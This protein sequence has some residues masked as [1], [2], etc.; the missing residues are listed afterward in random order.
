MHKSPHRQTVSVYAGGHK[1]EGDLHLHISSRDVNQR[2][3]D[4]NQ[5][6]IIMYRKGIRSPKR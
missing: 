2:N 4:K 1:S 6:Y 5:K 3:K